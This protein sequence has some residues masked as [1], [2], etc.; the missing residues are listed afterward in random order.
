M[1]AAVGLLCGLTGMIAGF[2]ELL[3]GNV[4]T[5]GLI[6]STI[7]PSYSMWTT[8]GISDFMETESAIT[9]I[10]RASQLIEGV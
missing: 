9:I 7:G 3:Q 5:N 6:I 2:F 8:Y 1:R 10:A 4:A